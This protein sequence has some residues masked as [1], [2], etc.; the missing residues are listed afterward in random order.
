MFV[1]KRK[2]NHSKK[3]TI[4]LHKGPDTFRKQ[5]QNNFSKEVIFFLCTASKI[6]H[7]KEYFAQ[8]RIIYFSR[9]NGFIGHRDS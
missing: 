3:T 1:H 8:K 5:L 2:S 6:L 9:S 4:A 7:S